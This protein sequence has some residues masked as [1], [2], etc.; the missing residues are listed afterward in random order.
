M[1]R[2]ETK[3][4]KAPSKTMVRQQMITYKH[5]PRSVTENLNYFVFAGTSKGAC[6]PT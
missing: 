6:Q 4:N 1:V 2:M 3:Q 5:A